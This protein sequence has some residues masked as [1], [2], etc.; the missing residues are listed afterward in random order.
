YPIVA[1]GSTNSPLIS[2]QTAELEQLTVTKSSGKSGVIECRA[3]GFNTGNIHWY[4]QKDGEA[5]KWI[6]F[7]HK[8]G[9]K[10]TKDPDFEDYQAEKAEDSDIFTLTIPTLKTDHVATYYCASFDNH[11]DNCSSFPVQKTTL[12][13]LL[14]ERP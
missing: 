3:T 8:G 1:A 13:F 12:Q 11:S 14:N 9:E 2:L 7:M 5:L 10:S 4:Q 6:L